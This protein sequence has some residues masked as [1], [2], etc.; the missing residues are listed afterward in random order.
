MNVAADTELKELR[1][2]IIDYIKKRLYDDLSAEEIVALAKLT[3]AI[4]N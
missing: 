3:D 4:S 2:E 1:K